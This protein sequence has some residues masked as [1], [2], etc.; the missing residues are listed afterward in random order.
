MELHVPLIMTSWSLAAAGSR[1]TQSFTLM[2]A[3]NLALPRDSA[4]QVARHLPLT[5]LQ[6]MIAS[7][8]AA[9]SAA[10]AAALAAI[11]A[12]FTAASSAFRD[13]IASFC[14]QW[15]SPGVTCAYQEW[16]EASGDRKV[17]GRGGKLED[18]DFTFLVQCSKICLG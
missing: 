4:S 14:P 16:K 8:T 11:A 3:Q 7:F 6:A 13:A 12:A 10:I 2:L 5:L 18:K 17:R 1:H 9:A 15:R